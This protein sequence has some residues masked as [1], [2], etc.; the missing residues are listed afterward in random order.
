MVELDAELVETVDQAEAEALAD[1]IQEKELTQI[2][3]E[4]VIHLQQ[5]LLK[6][7]MVV[8]HLHQLIKLLVAVADLVLLEQM[9]LNQEVV[10]MAEPVELEQIFHQYLVLVLEYVE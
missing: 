6:D 10:E 9:V 3:E 2:V 4:M 7:M 1:L 5:V 8:I